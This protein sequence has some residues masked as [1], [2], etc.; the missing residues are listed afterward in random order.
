MEDRGN[1][2]KKDSTSSKKSIAL[3]PVMAT[4]LVAVIGVLGTAVGAYLQGRLNIELERQK[5]ESELILRGLDSA[6][7]NERANYLSFLVD[8]DLLS[9]KS[10]DKEYVDSLRRSPEAIP[11]V[12]SQQ[13]SGGATPYDRA[14]AREREGFDYLIEGEY[15]AAIEAFEEAERIYPTL[16]SVYE[17]RRLLQQN[18]DALDAPSVR[19]RVLET[20]VEEYAWGVPSELI[21]RLEREIEG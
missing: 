2:P 6:D 7:P 16:H 18:R 13:G 20:I 5:F 8:A 11:R 10:L 1:E 21:A 4:V 12:L 19:A 9:S 14:T 17:I 15:D 3:T